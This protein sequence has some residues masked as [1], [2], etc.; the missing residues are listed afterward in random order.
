MEELSFPSGWRDRLDEVAGRRRE[1]ALVA[2]LVVVIMSVALATW[3][4]SAP[5]RVAPPAAS[6]PSAPPGSP[7]ATMPLLH[8]HVAG[9]V[10]RPGLYVLAEGARVAD[11]IEA[12]GGPRKRAD[13]DLLNLAQVVTDGMKVEVLR[14]GEK[15]AS[16]TA[17]DALGE[18]AT[19]A[20]VSINSA[21]QQALE[22]IPGLGPVKAGAIVRYRDETGPFTAVEQV[23]EVSGIGPATFEQILPFITL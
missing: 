13:L 11:A 23:M 14:R 2:G 6:E 10:I 1:A 15:S 21:D 18:A 3:G 4:R 20:L 9:A 22:T 17:G 16:V 5:A 8:V 12:A 7:A 19:N